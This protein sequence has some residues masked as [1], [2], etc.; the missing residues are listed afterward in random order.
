MLDRLIPGNSALGSRLFG[1]IPSDDEFA[2]GLRKTEGGIGGARAEAMRQLLADSLQGQARDVLSR[3]E[4][5]RQGL[6]REYS[7]AE[8]RRDQA[9]RILDLQQRGM[10]RGQDGKPLTLTPE[11]RILYSEEFLAGAQDST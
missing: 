3:R 7:E 2:I 10:L 8:R 4:G 9:G 1:E 6:Q 11:Q 5:T